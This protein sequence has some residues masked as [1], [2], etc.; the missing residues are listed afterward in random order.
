MSRPSRIEELFLPEIPTRDLRPG[1]CLIE[2]PVADERGDGFSIRERGIV[3]L[4]HHPGGRARRGRSDAYRLTCA[5]WQA[6]L[7]VISNP[8]W[9]PCRLIR[10]MVVNWDDALA[11]LLADP[12]TRD[13]ILS[14][15]DF[16]ELLHGI[17]IGDVLG[18]IADS[19]SGG[20][21]RAPMAFHT[22]H[23]VP[24]GLSVKHRAAQM[25]DLLLNGRREFMGRVATAQTSMR[26]RRENGTTALVEAAG[27]AA[28]A[29]V[30]ARGYIRG[31]VVGPT[32]ADGHRRVTVG[33]A[34]A[35]HTDITGFLRALPP[36]DWTR[37][38]QREP[39]W[40]GRDTIGGG[41]HTGSALCDSDLWRLFAV[42]SRDVAFAD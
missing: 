24:T 3:C 37:A 31:I 26:V 14:R 29:A 19:F 2:V 4:G 6:Y 9:R 42:S 35:C 8:D 20:R 39:G 7:L 18:P 5:A 30:Y 1:D 33:Q 23:A 11:A 41:P 12:H 25:A 15:G 38:Q 13:R 16:Q 32:D 17:A 10:G 40:G 36:I 28:L 21:R 34:V 22:P 27:P